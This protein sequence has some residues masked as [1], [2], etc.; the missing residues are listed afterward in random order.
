MGPKTNYSAA[1]VSTAV[2]NSGL[3]ANLMQ[4]ADDIGSLSR[5][6]SSG[7]AGIYNGTCCTGILQMNRSNLAAQGLTPQ[8]Y[9]NLPLQDQV[10]A[11]AKLTN[12]AANAGS[13]KQL[14]AMES[15]DGKKVDGAMVMACIQLGVGNCQK[16]INSGSC[17]GFA[18]SNGTTICKMADKIRGGAAEPGSSD[19]QTKTDDTKS[20]TGGSSDLASA[21]LKNAGKC[22]A[23]T[24][25][26]KAG[27]VTVQVV[28][29]ALESLTQPI[30]P[31]LAVIFAIVTVFMVGR[32]FIWPG[33][34]R[35]SEIFWNFMRFTAVWALLSTANYASEYVL[36]YAFYP[37]LQM[38]SAIGEI[39]GQQFN[40]AFKEQG[41]A[42]ECV[43]APV[44]TSIPFEGR[45]TVEHMATLACNVHN[46]A[47]APVVAGAAMISY[48]SSMATPAEVATAAL[49]SILAAIMIFASL[50]AL[51]AFAMSVVEA[52]LKLCI[53]LSLSPI[54]LFFWIFRKTRYL[55]LNAWNAVLYSF[56]LLAFAGLLASISSFV[57]ARLIGFGMGAAGSTPSAQ[58]VFQ[59]INTNMASMNVSQLVMFGCFSVAGS[60]M[61]SHL[62]RS[63]S[64]MASSLTGVRMGQ[65]TGNVMAGLNSIGQKA[66]V[67]PAAGAGMLTTYAGAK[68][69]AGALG[70]GAAGLGQLAKSVAGGPLAKMPGASVK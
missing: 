47:Y 55:A 16:M 8:E 59:W 46:A 10:N 22:W 53:V 48:K 2:R 17:S 15:F 36:G 32:G 23:C 57:L 19:G 9:A 64:D 14:M 30:M 39:G 31:L 4:Y 20:D 42:G 33:A 37:A 43:F 27:E 51:A 18:D 24:I 26:V 63:G 38:G 49:M 21:I 35:W 44:D 11:W 29:K 13:V 6:E 66:F 61:A 40:A 25:I 58:A 69:G 3:N 62:I 5:F 45:A 34:M 60:M 56:F 68:A 50:F 52:L 67:L 7:N 28:P 65:L 54:I 1:E 41:S 12:S 70:L